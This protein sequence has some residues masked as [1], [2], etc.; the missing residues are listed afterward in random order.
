MLKNKNDREEVT[1]YDSQIALWRT[2]SSLILR[3]ETKSGR[4]NKQD[5]SFFQNKNN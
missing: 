5:D 3:R 1:I 2:A 4:S